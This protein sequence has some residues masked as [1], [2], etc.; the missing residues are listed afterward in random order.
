MFDSRTLTVYPCSSTL[1]PSGFLELNA[2]FTQSVHQGISSPSWLKKRPDLSI[3]SCRMVEIMFSTLSGGLKGAFGPPIS[4]LTHPEK[5]RMVALKKMFRS[6]KFNLQQPWKNIGIHRKLCNTCNI[7][8]L[9]LSSQG[10]HK[11]IPKNYLKSGI[12]TYRD[13]CWSQ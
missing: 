12:F 10:H 1:Q 3:V 11:L 6:T 4:V 9:P 8:S 13:A 5:F 7:Y 2:Y